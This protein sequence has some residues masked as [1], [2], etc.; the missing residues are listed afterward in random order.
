MHWSSVHS[1]HQQATIMC[2]TSP[3]AWG[4]ETFGENQCPNSMIREG[5]AQGP[6]ETMH[7]P[8]QTI[9]YKIAWA[10]SAC[11]QLIGVFAPLLKTL[12][13][14]GYPHDAL[15]RLWSNCAET[16]PY[17][18]L[19]WAHMH[20]CRKCSTLAY[21]SV[22]IFEPAHD[23]TTKIACWLSE[24]SDQLGHPPSLIRVFA[25]CLMDS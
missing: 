1:S 4:G 7:E 23:K 9:S 2:K 11:A 22:Y 20:S 17:L 12:W 18:S 5:N 21:Q 6:V 13:I 15:Q 14:L 16:Q 10:H 24:D 3:K 8:N 25:V 19:H